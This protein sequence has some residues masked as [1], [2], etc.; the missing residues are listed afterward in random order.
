M[1]VKHATLQTNILPG[2]EPRGSKHVG[3]N[4]YLKLNINIFVP[5]VG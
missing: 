4:I 1:H 2:G 3:D 5:F